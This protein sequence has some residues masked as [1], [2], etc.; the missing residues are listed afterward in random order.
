MVEKKKKK[1]QKSLLDENGGGSKA[2]IEMFKTLP[3]APTA[4]E[5]LKEAR[6]EKERLLTSLLDDDA[7]GVI[8]GMREKGYG[9]SL[10]AYTTSKAFN[11][12]FSAAFLKRYCEAIEQMAAVE[13][14]APAPVTRKVTKD[15]V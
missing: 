15:S 14:T 9:W 8:F 7:L 2:L 11:Q 12:R 1:E 3:A 10:I 5:R 13:H 6:K 4:Q